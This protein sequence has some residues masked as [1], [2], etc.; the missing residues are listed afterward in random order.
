MYAPGV[1]SRRAVSRYCRKLSAC[2]SYALAGMAAGLPADAASLSSLS[3]TTGRTAANAGSGRSSPQAHIASS[4]NA[5]GGA[6]WTLSRGLAAASLAPETSVYSGPRTDSAKRTS[7]RTVR[8]MY[9]KGEPIVMI[10]AYDY[11]SAV[12][13]STAPQYYRNAAH[14]PQ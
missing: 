7:V 14:A 4:F 11:P 1:V 12:H 10:T 3:A 5:G 2:G 6:G 8:K 13:V 9:E